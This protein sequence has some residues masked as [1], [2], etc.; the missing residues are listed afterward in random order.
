M[1]SRQLERRKDFIGSIV[2]V[3]FIFVLI[4]GGFFVTKYLTSDT[5]KDKIKKDQVN[6]LKTNQKEELVYYE[7]EDVISEE[8]EIVYKDIVINLVGNSTTNDILKE[9]MDKIRTSVKKISES[10]LDPNKEVLYKEN[11]IFTAKERN[12]NVY[13]S[14]NYLS[15][16]I[17]DSNFNCYTGSDISSVKSYTFS[18]STGKNISNQ[19]LLG[20]KKL[21][22]D[23][24]KNK[25]REKLTKDQADFGEDTTILID[26]TVNVINIDNACVYINKTGK[27]V[28]SVIVK[29]S[30]GSYNDVIELE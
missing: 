26:D 8:P 27:L 4:V 2:F 29:T 25:V 5:E 24:V 21:D 3:S 18:L 19:T 7:N 15:V 10:E 12:Y 6:N 16:V 1:S 11:D 17:V 14:S 23:S 28:I 30:E 9:E 22:I 20:Y 13:E